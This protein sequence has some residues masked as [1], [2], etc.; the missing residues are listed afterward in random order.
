MAMMTTP[1]EEERAARQRERQLQRARKQAER[2]RRRQTNAKLQ[3]VIAEEVGR[4]R[5]CHCPFTAHT[6][7]D[8]IMAMGSGCTAGLWI[9]PTLD[10]IRRRMGR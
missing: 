4:G 3:A 6:T 5:G 8:D 2:Q 9:C 10:A 7:M 1:Y